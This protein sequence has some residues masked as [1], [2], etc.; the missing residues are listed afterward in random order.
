MACQVFCPWSVCPLTMDKRN[1][2]QKTAC[3]KFDF[4]DML[5][6][7]IPLGRRICLNLAF[8]NGTAFI[9]LQPRF[10]FD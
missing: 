8:D 9:Q 5:L 3:A 1:Q 2:G 6:A 4:M 10:S 7:P